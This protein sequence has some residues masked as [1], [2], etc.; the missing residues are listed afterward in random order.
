MNYDVD[1]DINEIRLM[2]V[3]MAK[4]NNGLNPLKLNEKELSALNG[5]ESEHLPGELV[6]HLRMEEEK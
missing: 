1:F 2:H 3:L 5:I 4:M 6:K